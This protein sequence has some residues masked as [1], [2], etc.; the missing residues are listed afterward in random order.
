M[1][2]ARHFDGPPNDRRASGR[3]GR[4]T[5][6]LLRV[7]HAICI[8][9]SSIVPAAYVLHAARYAHDTTG[10]VACCLRADACCKFPAARLHVACAS[11]ILRVTGAVRACTFCV[12]CCIACLSHNSRPMQIRAR[13]EEASCVAR[14]ND[15]LTCAHL[16]PLCMPP[17][18]PFPPSAPPPHT[19]TVTTTKRTSCVKHPRAYHTD[20]P[21]DAK[22][23]SG[24][25]THS[26]RAPLHGRR[27]RAH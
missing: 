2:P 27:A 20:E 1:H 22:T 4:C 26:E 12:A 5:Y 24:S 9:A 18:P 21:P 14:R 15:A 11:A 3:H 10:H 23:R 13:I 16:V 17:P 6:H 25:R 7:H 8:S 19:T